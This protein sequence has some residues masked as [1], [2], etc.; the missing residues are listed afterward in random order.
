VQVAAHHWKRPPTPRVPAWLCLVILLAYL[1]LG[2]AW[3]ASYHSVHPVDAFHYCFSLL[4]TIGVTRLHRRSAAGQPEEPEDL[5]SVLVTSTY[6]LVGVAL[7]S[8][9]LHFL[10]HGITALVSS[11]G[12]AA[13]SPRLPP[14]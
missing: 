14:S 1:G 7:V 9:C 12:P 8:M 3:V 13:P 11:L 4:A 10:Q 6:I 5:L 2:S